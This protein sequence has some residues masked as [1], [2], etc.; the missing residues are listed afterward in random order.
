MRKTLELIYFNLALLCVLLVGM[1][2]AGQ[3]IFYVW[4]GYPVFR[5]PARAEQGV[6]EL[7][8]YLVGR[9]RAGVHVADKGKVVTTT[10][11][12]TRW[13]GA[14][15]NPAA[16]RIA[17]VGGSTTF[18]AGVTD[19]DSWPARLQ[20][21]LGPDYAVT[22]FGMLGYSTAEGIVQMAL[23]IPETRPDIIVFYEGW[24]DI[25]SY[26]DSLPSP[27]YYTHGMRQYATLQLTPPARQTLRDRLV[28]ISA[29]W[30]LATVV[31]KQPADQPQ[32][33]QGRSY[34]PAYATPDTF[35]DRIYRRNLETLKLL[36]ERS[37]AYTVFVPQVLNDAWY[38][39]HTG[40]DWW[41]PHVDDHA[42]PS[43][44]RR[45][46]LTMDAVCGPQETRCSVLGAVRDWKWRPDDFIDEG[47]F[48]GKGGEAFARLLAPRIVE[49]A[50]TR[51]RL[52]SQPRPTDLPN[53]PHH[54]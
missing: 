5:P 44:I 34:G 20:V 15:T 7:H 42:M 27:D 29:I 4:K 10:P 14:P 33:V 21:I 22:N 37:G 9:P 45:F 41:T 19:T 28:D 30:R 51:A 47:H 46:G 49:A 26:H 12:H 8:P 31:A 17:V 53:D 50:A 38:A 40:G 1:E 6:V 43:L 54:L 52:K 23:L 39:Q 18:G 48:S 24:N 36:A 2:V 11:L 16:V 25:R 3:V 35:V 32:A 13:T